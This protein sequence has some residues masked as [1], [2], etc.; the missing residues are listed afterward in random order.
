M[1]DTVF[2]VHL[3]VT[4]KHE[5]RLS[6]TFFDEQLYLFRDTVDG[7]TDLE[8][9]VLM[10]EDEGAR[11]VEY[12]HK[13]EIISSEMQCET[14]NVVMKQPPRVKDPNVTVVTIMHHA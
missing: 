14:Y 4:T 6:G 12:D 1:K 3:T 13:G 5:I 11:V 10:L 8:D 2:E 9:A 7:A